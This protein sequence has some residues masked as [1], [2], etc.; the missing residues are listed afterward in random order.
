MLTE[1]NEDLIC[2]IF[3][4]T[5]LD[6]NFTSGLISFIIF[7]KIKPSKQ[8]KGLLATI[9]TRPEAGI[10]CRS[11]FDKVYEIFKCSNTFS[12]NSISSIF[13]LLENKSFIS[14]S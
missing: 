6:N 14:F 4:K 2:E 1:I 8:P 11:L 10:L 3:A 9:T 12:K 7:N 5:S 13:L